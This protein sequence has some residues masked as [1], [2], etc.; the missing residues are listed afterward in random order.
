MGP[1]VRF[2]TSVLSSIAGAAAAAHPNE[3]CGALLGLEGPLPQVTVA[4]PVVNSESGSPRDRFEVAPRDYLAV[5]AEAERRGLVLHGFWHSHPDG[6]ALPSTTDRAC[7]WEGLLTV[8]VAVPGGKAK[9]IGAWG[10]N[11]ANA[12]FTPVGIVAGEEARPVEDLL[13]SFV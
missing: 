6:E 7:A 10:L 11:G 8:I 4:L 12:P 3:A 13:E 2:E 5:E 9:E 1:V